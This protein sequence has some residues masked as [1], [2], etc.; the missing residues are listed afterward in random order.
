[1]ML[2]IAVAGAMLLVA[3]VAGFWI[4][5]SSSSSTAPQPGQLPSSDQYNFS[6]PSPPMSGTLN[7]KSLIGK[8]VGDAIDEIRKYDKETPMIRIEQGQKPDQ[9]YIRNTIDVL[10]IIVVNSQNKVVD[11]TKGDPKKLLKP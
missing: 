4:M 1:M 3:V 5:S 8:D 7:L 9:G 10:Y 2:L 11:V 6:Q